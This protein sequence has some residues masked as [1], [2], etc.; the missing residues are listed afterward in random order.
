M[1]LCQKSLELRQKKLSKIKDED[2]EAEEDPNCE[3]EA[4]F[5]EDDEDGIEI[6]ESDDEYN[7]SENGWDEEDELENELYDTKIDKIDEIL[8]VRDQINILQQ[9]N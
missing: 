7:D 3:R 2:D 8:Y 5:E 4:I 1:V 6:G 9:T